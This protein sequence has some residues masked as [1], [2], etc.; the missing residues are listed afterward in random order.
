MHIRIVGLL[1]W[2]WLEAICESLGTLHI[3]WAWPMGSHSSKVPR[4]SFNC[5]FD[6]VSGQSSYLDWLHFHPSYW[7]KHERVCGYVCVSCMYIYICKINGKVYVK[8]W[9]LLA[10]SD[11]LLIPQNMYRCIWNISERKFKIPPVFHNSR[12]CFPSGG[13]GG[14]G[15]KVKVS[16][17]ILL[18]FHCSLSYAGGWG[19]RMTW[20][21]DF[22]VF[23]FVLLAFVFWFS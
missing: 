15:L 20:A 21:I 2:D 14:N 19:W 3:L 23:C 10:S 8:N 6:E 5:H 13:G 4:S 12:S 9:C 16:L 17:P 11:N 18:H 22:G 1:T 7:P